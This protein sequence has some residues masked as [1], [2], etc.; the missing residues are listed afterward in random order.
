MTYSRIA[1]TG[2]YLPERVMTNAEIDH[3]ADSLKM[4]LLPDVVFV[5]EKDGEVVGFSLS[6]PDVNQ[7][8][9][10]ARPRSHARCAGGI[11][12]RSGHSSSSDAPS[13]TTQSLCTPQLEFGF[14]VARNITTGGVGSYRA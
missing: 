13:L 1:G 9:H 8:I 12:D 3:L 4:I 10:R 14:A 11:L 2:S 6:L 7:V 5:V